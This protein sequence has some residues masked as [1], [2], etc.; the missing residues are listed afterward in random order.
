MLRACCLLI[1]LLPATVGC[2]S[3]Y[4]EASIENDSGSP[5]KLVEVDYPSAGFGVGSLAAGARFPYRFKLQGSGPVKVDFTDVA[6]KVHH[7]EGP[8]LKEGQTGNLVVAIDASY[9]VHWKF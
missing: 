9:Q 8:M 4:I 7:A 5:I 1:L 3:A 2:R 6:G